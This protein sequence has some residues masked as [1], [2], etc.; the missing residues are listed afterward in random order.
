[1]LSVSAAWIDY[2]DDG[3]LDLF[4]TN[5]LDWTPRNSKVCGPVGKRLSCPPSMYTGEANILYHNNGDGTFTD[6]SQKT[7]I[8]KHIGK[9]M[10]VAIADYDG[11]GFMDIFV[12]NDTERNF[13]FHNLGAKAFEEVGVNAGVA[14]TE[15]GVTASS[16]AADFRDL[17][18]DGRPDL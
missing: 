2:D 5:Y 4:V 18:H 12:A 17:D 6:V 16:M 10:G 3:R 1:M 8:A 7:G 11:D 14:Y 15:D 13:L 9:G